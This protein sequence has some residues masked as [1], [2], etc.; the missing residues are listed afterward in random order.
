MASGDNNN[1]DNGNKDKIDEVMKKLKG[2]NG[3]FPF[4]YL[5][6]VIIAIVA[7]NSYFSNISTNTIPLSDFK[8]KIS[9][10]E[11]KYVKIV[12]GFYE[13]YLT[14]PKS[15]DMTRISS[16]KAV[17]L[18]ALT[19]TNFTK[20]LEDSKVEYEVIPVD[21]NPLIGM[22]LQW[23]IPLGLMFLIWRFMFKKIGGM[24]GSNVM[25]FGQN[26]SKILS[27]TNTGVV[28]NDVAG[29]EE[30]KYELEEVVDFLKNSKKYTEIGGKIPKGVLLVGP[31]GTGKTLMAKAVAGEAGVTFFRLSGADF[32]E[33]FVGVGAA[34]VRDLFKQAR[35]KSPAIIFIDELDAI[36]KSRAAAMSTNDE[37]EQTLNQLLVEMD[38][39]DTQTGV[40]LLAATN[41]PEILD[42]ALLRPGRFDRQVL[43]DKPDLLGREEILRI[44]SKGVKLDGD[45]CLKD[46]AK[47]TPGFVGA[48]LANIVNEAA[49][50]AVR[51]GRKT[52]IQSDFEEAI[53][54]SVAGLEKKNRLINP[55]EREI[56]AYH[57]VGHALVAAFTP[58]Q[59]PVQKISIVPRGFGALGYTMQTPT[60]DRFLM[61][62]EELIG[63]VDVLLGGRAAEL[64][65]YNKLSTG[66][67]ND[68]ER[69]TKIVKNMITVY[70]MSDR[71]KN[72]AL[73][74]Q[75]NS[76]LQGGG[77]T[78][79]YSETTQQYIDDEISK[80]LS[81]RYEHVQVLLKKHKVLLESLTEILMHDEVLTSEEFM[82]FVKEDAVGS[83]SYS[84]RK[85]LDMKPSERAQ[86]TGKKRNDEILERNKAIMEAKKNAPPKVNVEHKKEN[87]F[88]NE[89]ELK[90]KDPTKDKKEDK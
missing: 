86:E 52:V 65:I 87:P 16:Y 31:P 30:A 15:S 58:D 46:V 68:I 89:V 43:V 9:T 38:G 21:N 34:R 48:D 32:V 88:V 14:D 55:R 80:V 49:L 39:F 79:E 7:I 12:D 70:G 45:L 24:G 81:E 25:N 90:L 11:I 66:A 41:R 64:L 69:A 76:Y 29:C 4:I 35:E 23:V 60:E 10:G 27:E 53:E 74:V 67:S 18:P 19:D 33:M 71:F 61:T 73:S 47:A 83:Q 37:R 13:G 78:K 50:L 72:V 26:K 63:E 20:M 2:G 42:P 59:N 22:L 82:K 85:A 1:P 75:Q 8:Y 56:V 28:F 51:A 57:E 6:G 44:H 36:G 3:K 62:E 40:I 84:D 77:S 54:K 5:I 17:P